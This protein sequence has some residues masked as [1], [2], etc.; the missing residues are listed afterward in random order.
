VAKKTTS[1]RAGSSRSSKKTAKT[2]TK[3]STTKSTRS[4][5]KKTTKK[6]PSSAKTTTGRAKT[7]KSASKTRASKTVAKPAKT[8]KA[9]ATAD[10]KGAAASSAAAEK[11]PL[12]LV[13]PKLVQNSTWRSGRRRVTRPASNGDS[14]LADA[15]AKLVCSDE[16]PFLSETALKR[17]K[18]DLTRKPDREARADSW[19]CGFARKARARENRLGESIQRASAHVR[20]RHGQ[21]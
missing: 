12:K 3:K 19:R 10:A 20:R 2:S 17:A 6:A 15:A 5:S 4:S 14:T 16:I 9:A 21:L 13:Q 18:S 1:S 8:G 11:A 7:S